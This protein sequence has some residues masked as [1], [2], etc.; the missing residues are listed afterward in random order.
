MIPAFLNQAA[1]SAVAAGEALA[2]DPRFALHSLVPSTLPHAVKAEI[3]RGT[4]RILVAGGDGTVAAAASEAVGRPVQLAILPGGTLNHFAKDYGIPL[5]PREALEVSAGTANR[6]VD[7]GF[8]NDRLFLNTSSVGAYVSFVHRRDRL[9][10]HLGYRL[11]SLVAALRIMARLR[12]YRIELQIE[13]K[14]RRYRTPLVFIGVDERD[15]RLPIFGSR[16]DNGQSGLHAIVVRGKTRARIMAIA[17]AAAAR[18]I[19]AVSRT[20]HLDSFLVNHCRI[21]LPRE[22]SY[23]GLDGETVPL[24]TPLRYRI[25]RRALTLVVPR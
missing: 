2:A 1:G 3:K 21:D 8:V 23:V 19:R 4:R 9:E 10:P 20:P 11:G 12:S 25:V 14:I 22:W 15:L 6:R 13:G 7:V 24:R 18:G 5:D 17:L 16:M